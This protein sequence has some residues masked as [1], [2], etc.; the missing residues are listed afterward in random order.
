[1]QTGPER[2]AE[3]K[4]LRR[5]AADP[6]LPTYEQVELRRVEPFVV[7]AMPT[8]MFQCIGIRHK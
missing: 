6:D 4:V 8:P 7:R 5:A 2:H 3:P 1:M